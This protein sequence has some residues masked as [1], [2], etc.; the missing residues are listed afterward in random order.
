[1]TNEWDDIRE[2]DVELIPSETEGEAPAPA[3]E[4]A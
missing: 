2:E 1:M 3:L 4:S